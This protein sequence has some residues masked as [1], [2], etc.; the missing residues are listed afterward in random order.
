MEASADTANNPQMDILMTRDETAIKLIGVS[1]IYQLYGSQRD[2]LVS[3]LG[4]KRIGIGVRTQPK[5]FTALNNISIEVKRGQRLGIIGR[6][7][8][9]KTT[10]LKLICGNF[11]PSCGVVEVNGNVQALMTMGLGFHP[12]YTGRENVEASLQYSGLPRKQYQ[13][14][15]KD[16]IDFCE[17]K[18]YF[19]QPFR[20]YSLGMQA[21]LMFASATAISPDILIVDEMLGAGDAYFL[22]KCRKRVNN[23]VNSG[24]TLLLVSHSMQQVLELCSEAIWLDHG[25]IRM[26]G[27]AFSV[28]KAY[29]EYIY[30]INGGGNDSENDEGNHTSIRNKI[31]Q[32]NNARELSNGNLQYPCFLPHRDHV[33]IDDWPQNEIRKFH[34]EAS[35]GISHWAGNSRL[36]ITGFSILTTRGMTNK[37]IALEPVKFVFSL[38]SSEDA[39]YSCRYGILVQDIAGRPIIRVFSPAD[40]FFLN[41][42]E[43]RQVEMLLNPNQIGPGNYIVG[44]SVSENTPGEKI[45]TAERY[46]LLNRS[47]EF[48]VEVPDSMQVISAA[49][50]H[51]AE[52]SFLSCD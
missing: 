48:E 41:A 7:G 31:E 36:R 34:F 49:F 18:E 52:W 40:N 26:R 2:Q 28:V 33:V 39:Q 25:M 1:K 23:L 12:D 20:T 21:R 10:L 29:E 16:I 43:Y 50:F 17:L 9:G 45:N 8:A 42:R 11:S 32:V 4:L 46:D 38:T 14:A 44:I 35:G 47:F 24:C 37:L 22:E 15:L 30:G 6:N 19:D 13:D 51:S 27:E 5:E 3:V